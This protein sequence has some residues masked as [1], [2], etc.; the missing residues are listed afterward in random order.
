MRLLPTVYVCNQLVKHFG[1]YINDV[2][3]TRINHRVRLGDIVSL[4]NAQ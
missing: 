2:K 3:V 1:I 4:S